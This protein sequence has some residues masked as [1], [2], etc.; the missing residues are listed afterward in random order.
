MFSQWY[1][2]IIK[3]DKAEKFALHQVGMTACIIISSYYGGLQVEGINKIDVGVTRKHWNGAMD[4]P[5]Y[6][7]VPLMLT[8]K[9]KK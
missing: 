2:D 6:S 9:F 8:G 5:E 1:D 7:H 4:H 3:R